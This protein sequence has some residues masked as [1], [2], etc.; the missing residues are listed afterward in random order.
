MRF[1]NLTYPRDL[2]TTGWPFLWH[3]RGYIRD[4]TLRWRVQSTVVKDRDKLCHPH[5]SHPYP[6]STVELAL[7]VLAGSL[8]FQ[9]E[10]YLNP[11]TQE[12]THPGLVG[13]SLATHPPAEPCSSRYQHFS[14][15]RTAKSAPSL[16]MAT[17]KQSG[18]MFGN[19]DTQS[20]PTPQHRSTHLFQ[21]SMSDSAL[22]GK[23]YSPK[24]PRVSFESDPCIGSTSRGAHPSMYPPSRDNPPSLIYLSCKLQGMQET[25]RA[26][27]ALK[28]AQ[29]IPPEIIAL[30]NLRGMT[31][32]PTPEVI[33][34]V[35]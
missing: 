10:T 24:Q 21:G 17:P 6:V 23:E 15:S 20:F 12:D 16:P 30:R 34:L 3:R 28:S 8:S 29:E 1:V 25:P 9:T 5:C 2:R 33:H 35:R 18:V 11:F 7:H 27:S 22:V 14:S 19:V 32:L 31:I 26:I 13:R 4:I